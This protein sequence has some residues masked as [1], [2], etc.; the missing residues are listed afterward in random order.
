MH[1]LE[2]D[3]RDLRCPMPIV[4]ISA[5]IQ[6]MSPGEL[7]RVEANDPAFHADV[8]AWSSMTGNELVEFESGEVQSAVIRVQGS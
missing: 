4:R 6:G 5:A 8:E 7:L 2:L 1:D 3:C